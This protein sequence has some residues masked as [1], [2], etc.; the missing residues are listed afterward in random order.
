MK[1][2]QPKNST[3]PSIESDPAFQR[4]LAELR[5]LLSSTYKRLNLPLPSRKS[6]TAKTKCRKPELPP[7]S[8]RRVQ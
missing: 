1:K 6:T 4:L 5:E 8:R 7:K 3:E 2:A